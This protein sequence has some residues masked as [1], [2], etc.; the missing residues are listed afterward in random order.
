MH[1]NPANN[2]ILIGAR[3][4]MNDFAS[5]AARASK[6]IYVQAMTFEGDTAGEELV[7]LLCK[8]QGVERKIC[9][10]DYSNVVVN[11]TFIASPR[12]LRDPDFRREVQQG[13]KLV[14]M[15]RESGVGVAYTNPAGPLL[16]RYPFRNHKKLVICDNTVYIGGINF[17]EHNFAW[18]DMMIR[19]DDPT[20]ADLLAEDF[21]HN[22]SG[23]KTCRRSAW[24]SG[25][26][27]L[28]NRNKDALWDDLLQHFR[29]A[30]KNITIVSPYV[31][32][33]LLEVLQDCAGQPPESDANAKDR[34]DQPGSEGL[35][36][37]RQ[38]SANVTAHNSDSG[39]TLPRIRII[40]PEVNNKSLF[41]KNLMHECAKGYFELYLYK[42]GMSHLK[43]ALIDDETL[44]AGSS[45][46]DFASYFFEEEVMVTI[47]DTKVINAFQLTILQPM[48]ANAELVT[49]KHPE[50]GSYSFSSRVLGTF[51][52]SLKRIF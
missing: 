41:R 4:F 6:R 36:A 25:E 51:T 43:A 38:G 31:S 48:F 10:D 1:N 18:H 7:A 23:Q 50:W 14:E 20:L 33:P 42:G 39:G 49:P 35:P 30:Q 19:L 21:L 11:D 45:N 5:A 34:A 9:I 27:Y 52:E 44:I 47:R 40:T 32:W 12:W 17:S 22:F 13:K 26:V 2:P 46:Y 24:S 15:S 16:L 28:L 37:Y 3:S 29:S 8:A